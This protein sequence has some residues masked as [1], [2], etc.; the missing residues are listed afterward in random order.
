MPLFPSRA[1]SLFH[2]LS[3]L[4]SPFIRLP[5][6]GI[7]LS[8]PSHSFIQQ[9]W[10]FYYT[11]P[12]STDLSPG[13]YSPG[14]GGEGGGERTSSLA[15]KLK[16]L[17]LHLRSRRFHHRPRISN[18]NR[19]FIRRRWKTLHRWS[20]RVGLNKIG[21]TSPSSG[22]DEAGE[23]SRLTRKWNWISSF[24]NVHFFLFSLPV[25]KPRD[26]RILERESLCNKEWLNSTHR[27]FV[28]NVFFSFVVSL[29]V[30][31]S[32]RKGGISWILSKKKN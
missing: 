3:P 23:G 18:T 13:H 6:L 32:S 28:F 22:V 14:R 4:Y 31:I 2:H 8:L 21:G 19:R 12:T 10:L 26:T 5:C 29:L 20:S 25:K 11:C 9:S 24:Y 30:K 1:T 17:L 7:F 15:E 16:Y 27:D